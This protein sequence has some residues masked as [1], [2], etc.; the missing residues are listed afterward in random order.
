MKDAKSGFWMM[1][2]ATASNEKNQR[3]ATGLYVSARFC[4][5]AFLSKCIWVNMKKNIFIYNVRFQAG[6]WARKLSS[7]TGDLGFYRIQN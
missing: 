5:Y 4:S 3:H 6:G 2:T 1:R 7:L